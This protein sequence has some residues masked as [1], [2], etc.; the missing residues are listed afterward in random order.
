M[1][2]PA[3]LR[4]NRVAIFLHWTMALLILGMIAL[5]L[6][7][8]DFP[9]KYRFLAFNLHKSFGITILALTLLRI[10]WRL[11][12]R[13]P[14]LPAHMAGWER[15]AADASHLL[16]Y[17]FM[18]AIP[19][20]GWIMV[21]A[22]AK[23]PTIFFSLFEVPQFPLPAAYDTH[24]THDRFEGLHYYLAMSAL[25]LAMLHG[26]AALKHHFFDRDDVLRRMLPRSIRRNPEQ[27]LPHA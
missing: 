16:L 8:E 23:Y 12:H 7:M 6:T 4:Y 13:P 15:R 3:S 17:F 20:S 18:L 10:T 24:D 1:I 21:S 26:L 11:M 25:A 27:E 9:I 5:G 14:P 22:D 2:E 19:L